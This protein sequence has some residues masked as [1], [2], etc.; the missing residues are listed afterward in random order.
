MQSRRLSDVL[1]YITH[2][3]ETWVIL[4]N[5]NYY[6]TFMSYDVHSKNT[7]ITKPPSTSVLLISTFTQLHPHSPSSFQLPPSSLQ[8]PRRYWNQN[9]ARNW[10]ISPN[11]G[12][13]I[14]SSLFWRKI[15]THG[16]LE[17]QIPNPY[18]D[19]WNS[20]P[21]ILFWANL[22]WKSQS[23][24]W[25]LAHMVS[26]RWWFLFQYYSSEFATLNLFLGKFRTR[27]FWHTW[28]IDDADSCS[29]IS[30]LYFQT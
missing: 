2:L 7:G 25:I 29:K 6:I 9:I 1:H 17:V 15:G 12:Q 13:K 14:L 22:G 4:K 30:F 28:H 20:D 11:L 19:F 27:K 8:H 18:L 5:K 23:F 21:K 16:T 26:R 24:S 3:Q 10:A